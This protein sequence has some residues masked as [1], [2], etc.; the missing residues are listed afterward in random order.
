MEKVFVFPGRLRFYCRLT[1]FPLAVMSSVPI[2]PLAAELPGA[3][4]V[5]DHIPRCEDAGVRQRVL[6]CVIVVWAGRA[7]A[8]I[9]QIHL[10]KALVD[11]SEYGRLNPEQQRQLSDV[12]CSPL[13]IRH[14]ALWSL[15]YATPVQAVR[16]LHRG[17]GWAFFCRPNIAAGRAFRA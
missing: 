7:R 17:L 1:T 9:H 6:V 8:E 2:R 16:I 3:K 11:D 13:A 4:E 10:L 15:P 14:L 5:C 12:F